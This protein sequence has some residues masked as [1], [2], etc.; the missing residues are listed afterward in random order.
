M[1]TIAI[2]EPSEHERRIL[3]PGFLRGLR[4]LVERENPA[5]DPG[6]GLV[7]RWRLDQV[8]DRLAWLPPQL[9]FALCQAIHVRGHDLG[10]LR[11]RLGQLLDVMEGDLAD[12][13]RKERRVTYRRPGGKKAR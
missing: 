2:R 5:V 9:A 12:A 11:D 3:P 1:P 7:M 8:L 4:E 6:D 13:R 10:V